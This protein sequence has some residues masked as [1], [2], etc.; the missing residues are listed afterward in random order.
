M[1]TR[2]KLI[3][4]ALPLDSINAESARKRRRRAKAPLF[5]SPACSQGPPPLLLLAPADLAC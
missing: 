5:G 2:K 4:V 1:T 3:E